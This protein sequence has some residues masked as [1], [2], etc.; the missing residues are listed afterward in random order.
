M[1]RALDRNLCEQKHGLPRLVKA[2]AT[3]SLSG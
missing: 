2:S 3:I 1:R